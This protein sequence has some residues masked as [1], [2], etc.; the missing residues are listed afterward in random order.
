[1]VFS[2]RLLRHAVPPGLCFVSCA[3]GTAVPGFH[4]PPFGL[5]LLSN[6]PARV[7]PPLSRSLRQGG[8][9]AYFGPPFA[10]GSTSVLNPLSPMP[11][12][13]LSNSVMLI[14][15]NDSNRAGTCAAI[16]AKSPVILFIP[17]DR[18]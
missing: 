7:A 17:V 1:M 18:K 14:P 15:D 8:D 12:T 16:L 11:R 9:F 2:S 3:P 10:G 13:L 5:D 4:M 6:T